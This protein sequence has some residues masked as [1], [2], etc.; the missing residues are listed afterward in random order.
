MYPVKILENCI[1]RANTQHRET[2]YWVTRVVC[3]H[4][5]SYETIFF[6]EE[7]SVDYIN[8]FRTFPSYN[9]F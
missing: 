5:C 6:D 4:R 9:A 3:A 7:Q 2:I 8:N 1:D